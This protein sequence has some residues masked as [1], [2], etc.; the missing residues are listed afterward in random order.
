MPGRAQRENRTAEQTTELRMK[1]SQVFPGQD[2]TVTLQLQL[3]PAE[4]DINLLSSFIL[5]Q[6]E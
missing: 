5:E 4:T 6:M 2:S 1:L 3:H